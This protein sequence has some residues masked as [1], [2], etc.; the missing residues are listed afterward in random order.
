MVYIPKWEELKEALA[1][2]IGTGIGENDAKRDICNAIAD[3]NVRVR[4]RCSLQPEWKVSE[5]VFIPPRLY[6]EDFWWSESR[7][8]V[9]K[10]PHR[11]ELG[12][13]QDL[14]DGLRLWEAAYIELCREDVTNALCT[15]LGKT[16][17]KADAI[18]RNESG[19]SKIVASKR[20]RLNP[21]RERARR[22]LS[23]LYPSGV[24]DP[25]TLTDKELCRAVW[26]HFEKRVANPSQRPLPLS[27]DT[28]LRAAG[29]R[30]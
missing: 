13:L 15:A 20:E 29:R 9:A 25:I 24:P 14:P 3:R 23:E 11:Y 5:E 4:I 2:V 21:K 17:A 19:A 10:R 28:I 12:L 6:P 16:P 8:N 22:A 1:R 26:D 30:K 18:A 27:D 7:W